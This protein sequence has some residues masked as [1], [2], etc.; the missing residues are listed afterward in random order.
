M[1]ASFSQL[2]NSL[3]PSTQDLVSALYIIVPAYCTNGAP[4]IFGGGIP[5]DLGKSLSDGNRIL[6]DNKTIRGILSGLMVGA[7][8]GA[9]EYYLFSKNLFLIA[10]LASVG[11]LF[12]DLVGAFLKRRLKI[13]PG[14][15]LPAI[16]QLDFVL[17]ALLFVSPVY[18][19]SLGA[20]V[21]LLLVTPPIHFL[22]NVAAYCLGLKRNYW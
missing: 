5:I 10:F 19:L 9:L 21:I 11:A 4:V 1:L 20:I 13:K 12:G 3:W 14:D 17:G 6:G 16:D 15:A 2:V 7:I 18:R 8:V 22:T